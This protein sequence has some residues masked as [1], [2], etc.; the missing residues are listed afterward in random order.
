MKRILVSGLVMSL[1]LAGCGGGG[2]GDS[3]ATPATVVSA[4]ATGR[5]NDTGMT[6]S[7]YDTN[8]NL[9]ACAQAAAG[10]DCNT[11]RDATANDDADGKTGFSFTK[12]DANGY[13]L[14]SSATSWSCVKDNV[15]GLIWENKTAANTTTTYTNIGDLRTGDVSKYVSTVNATGLCGAKDWRVPSSSEL[16]SLVYYGIAELH[17]GPLI[18]TNWFPNTQSSCYLSS[19]YLPGNNSFNTIC[20]NSGNEGPGYSSTRNAAYAAR[21]VRGTTLPTANRYQISSDGQEVTD[22]FT[23][24]IW[25]RCAEGMRWNGTSCTGT[26]ATYTHAAA[27][28][29]ARNEAQISGKA[30]R[31]PN[32]QEL[33]SI[34]DIT[35]EPLAINSIAFP[36]VSLTEPLYYFWTSTPV[37]G[38][39]SNNVWFVDFYYGR[40]VMDGIS[41]GLRS[42]SDALRLVRTAQ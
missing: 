11:G 34:V 19:R 18:D 7:G 10:N 35:Q 40:S 22:T 39:A 25:R 1:V 41:P 23:Q 12:I 3:G 14:P 4:N 37:A 31:M 33:G 30:W 16:R 21:L 17:L 38:Y 32:A 15:T 29:R 42:A 8:G 9:V 2:G 20:F 24:L 26:T 6:A 13:A 28:Q 36:G 27:L 5:L